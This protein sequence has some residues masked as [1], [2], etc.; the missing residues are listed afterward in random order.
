[1]SGKIKI[2]IALVVNE[3]GEW[4]AQGWSNPYR[5]ELGAMPENVIDAVDNYFGA[6]DGL[7]RGYWVT[8]EVDKPKNDNTSQVVAGT[9]EQAS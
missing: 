8:L 4:F 2:R 6:P 9:A 5:G 1:M 7:R 3:E